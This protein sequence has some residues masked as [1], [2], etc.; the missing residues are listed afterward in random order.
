[1]TASRI[2]ASGGAAVQTLRSAD[3]VIEAVNAANG[4]ITAVVDL[5]AIPALPAQL[6]AGS[7][8]QLHVIGFAPHV[9]VELLDAAADTCDEV[10]P[11]G[12]VAR[13]IARLVE[14]APVQ[15]PVE[16]T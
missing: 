15:S 4:P 5:T 16:G 7:A 8:S 9:R 12:A 6:R 3:A 1:M 11:R 2:E 13:T 14:A 10:L